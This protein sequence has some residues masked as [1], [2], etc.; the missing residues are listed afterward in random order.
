[1]KYSHLFILLLAGI[2]CKSEAVI[3]QNPHLN[4]PAHKY[5]IVRIATDDGFMRLW[6]SFQTPRHRTNFLELVNRGFYNGLTFHRIVDEFVIQ[7]G[8]PNGDGT[9]GP[10]YEIPAE[11]G[12]NLRHRFGAL[13]AA[14]T[15]D[16]V[17]PK[18]RSSGSQFYLVEGR[19]GAH[20]LDGEYTVFGQLVSGYDVMETIGK[21]PVNP[22]TNRPLTPVVMRT[23]IVELYTRQEL[24]DQFGFDITEF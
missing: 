12:T 18:R 16:F 4:D 7:G 21:K 23:V 13:A 24:Q 15:S 14:R 3:P 19:T 17:N 6:L 1:M 9:G 10:G 20:F 2:S 8:D 22:T 5:E 11:I